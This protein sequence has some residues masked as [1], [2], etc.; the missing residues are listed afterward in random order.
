MSKG[1]KCLG[2]ALHCTEGERGREGGEREDKNDEDGHAR[3]GTSTTT[4]R[5]ARRLGP[6]Q[7]VT[8]YLQIAEAIHFSGGQPVRIMPMTSLPGSLSNYQFKR[9]FLSL[10]L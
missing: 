7:G 3:A 8:F 10:S 9:H 4:R 5:D 6:L 2:M 1:D